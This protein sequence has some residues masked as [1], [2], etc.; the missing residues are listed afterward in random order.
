MS[1][2]VLNSS[3][4]QQLCSG[5]V[6]ALEL[7]GDGAVSVWKNFV[8]SSDAAVAHKEAPQSARSQFGRD[9]AHGSDSLTSAARVSN[10]YVHSRHF[11]KTF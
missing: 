10:F 1:L 11:A 2:A 5:P 4:V 3:L 7:V 6:V 8:G 9:L